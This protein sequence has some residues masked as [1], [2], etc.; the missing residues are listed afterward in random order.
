[1]STGRGSYTKGSFS[2]CWAVAGLKRK[3]RTK[4]KL[5]S[6]DS[7]II[8]LCLAAF[9]WA[10][11]QRTKGAVKLPMLLDHDGYLPCFAVMTKGKVADIKVAKQI[12]LCRGNDARV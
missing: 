8:P 1:M 10:H 3:F 5:L 12:E 7:T 9:D 4:H 6:L 2:N 11:Y